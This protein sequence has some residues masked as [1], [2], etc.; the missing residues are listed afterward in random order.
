VIVVSEDDRVIVGRQGRFAIF[1]ML[2]RDVSPHLDENDENGTAPSSM[3]E[4]DVSVREFLRRGGEGGRV[5][6]LSP[7]LVSSSLESQRDRL[8]HSMESIE[9]STFSLYLRRQHPGAL[10]ATIVTFILAG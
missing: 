3:E 8:A 5:I 7:H 1:V 2:S 4:E 10:S 6:Q 9:I